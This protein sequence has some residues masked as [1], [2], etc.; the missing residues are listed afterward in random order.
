VA[1][2]PRLQSEIYHPD[3]DTWQ[4]AAT[5]TVVRMYHSVA[6]LMPDATVMTASGNPPPYGNQVRW[7][8]QANEELRIEVFS[9]P[10][11]FAGRRPTI[12]GTPQHWAFAT[13]VNVETPDAQ[14]ILWAEL[15][16]P[17]VTTHSFDNAQRLVDLPIVTRA[18]GHVAVHTPQDSNLAPPSWYML[19]I[20]DSQ[21]V[22]S[23]AAWVH[24]S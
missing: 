20:V 12:D 19:F 7:I 18:A 1:K 11:L 17:G 4:P 3:T 10:Y 16:R 15:I 6:L 21:R 5:A 23:V 13:T 2:V 22:P 8:E 24:L 9:P 14:D